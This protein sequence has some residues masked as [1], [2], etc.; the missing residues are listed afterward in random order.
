VQVKKSCLSSFQELPKGE[1]VVILQL[2]N[3][4]IVIFIVS[5]SFYAK[6]LL[7]TI[8]EGIFGLHRPM[9]TVEMN[10]EDKGIKQRCIFKIIIKEWRV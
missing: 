9:F 6:S 10:T 1:I 7:T 4:P 5:S 3:T 2:N 8:S